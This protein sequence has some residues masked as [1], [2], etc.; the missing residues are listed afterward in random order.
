MMF[1]YVRYELIKNYNGHYY[2]GLER[3]QRQ[4]LSFC[5]PVVL[6]SDDKKRHVMQ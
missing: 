1:V 5:L 4:R 3:I 6:Q 2:V